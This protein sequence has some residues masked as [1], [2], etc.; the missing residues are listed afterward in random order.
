R[1]DDVRG[2]LPGA[3]GRAPEHEGVESRLPGYG[4]FR[5]GPALGL[6]DRPVLPINGIG[7]QAHEPLH[8]VVARPH[9]SV[10]EESGLHQLVEMRVIDA[11]QMEP[12]A[13]PT[14]REML[15][16][17]RVKAFALDDRAEL[18]QCVREQHHDVQ[19]ALRG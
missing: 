15:E 10:D 17:Q 4:V 14:E 19:L 1:W 8:G 9:R 12:G 7:G 5:A 3:T 13:A 6:D 18:Y 2:R 16:G 11:L